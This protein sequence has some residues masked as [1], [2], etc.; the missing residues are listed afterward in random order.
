VYYPKLQVIPDGLLL[1]YT[2]PPPLQR[3]AL[4]YGKRDTKFRDFLFYY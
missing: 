2:I 3:G 1:I 4:L